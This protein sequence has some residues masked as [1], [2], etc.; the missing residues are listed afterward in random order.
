MMLVFSMYVSGHRA[1]KALATMAAVLGECEQSYKQGLISVS[2]TFSPRVK[3][4]M[5][6]PLPAEATE[7]VG[8][9]AESV[10]SILWAS[11]RLKIER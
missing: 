8:G 5:F 4:E 2:K 10:F 3:L 1:N 7:C 9:S 6:S 11:L